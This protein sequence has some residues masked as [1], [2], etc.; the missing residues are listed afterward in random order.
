VLPPA[1]PPYQY[2]LVDSGTRDAQIAT[3]SS[4]PAPAAPTNASG[5][6]IAA[7]SSGGIAAPVD[8]GV[9]QAPLSVQVLDNNSE[10]LPASDPS[11]QRIYYRD[12]AT[13]TLITTCSLPARIR[14]PSSGSARMPGRIPTTAR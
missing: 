14:T 3:L 11:Y 7:A 8:S 12:D 1:P 6:Q 2:L 13:K 4:L 9:D 5:P 10:P